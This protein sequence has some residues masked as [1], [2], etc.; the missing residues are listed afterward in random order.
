[1]S[2]VRS[3]RYDKSYDYESDASN[4]DRKAV[5]NPNSRHPTVNKGSSHSQRSLL[6]KIVYP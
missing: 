3:K 5:N 1:M 2:N 6:V 4:E